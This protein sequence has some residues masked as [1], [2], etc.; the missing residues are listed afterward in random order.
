MELEELLDGLEPLT[1]VLLGPPARR[2]ALVVEEEALEQLLL[3]P[4]RER[5]AAVR[6]R[7]D[8]VEGDIGVRSAVREEA[9]CLERRRVRVRAANARADVVLVDLRRATSE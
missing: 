3:V 7:R 2:V 6:E 1:L 9:G 8:L 4:G 5:V